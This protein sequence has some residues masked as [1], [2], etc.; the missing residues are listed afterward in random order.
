[1]RPA[2]TLALAALLILILVAA[3]IQFVVLTR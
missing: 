1:M 3:V 2:T